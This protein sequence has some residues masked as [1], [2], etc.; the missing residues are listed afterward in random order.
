MIKR[1]N[2]NGA[3]FIA[4]FEFTVQGRLLGNGHALVLDKRKAIEGSHMYPSASPAAD[5]LPG[6]TPTGHSDYVHYDQVFSIQPTIQ[7]TKIELLTCKHEQTAV[8]VNF[9]KISDEMNFMLTYKMYMIY[10]SYSTDSQV[11][12]I[13]ASIKCMLFDLVTINIII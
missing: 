1:E 11:N 9:Q 2:R 6:W 3:S 13:C 7:C 10:H 8:A 12:N 5:T 4:F